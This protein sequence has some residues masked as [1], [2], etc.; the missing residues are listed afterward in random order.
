MTQIIEH[1]TLLFIKLK[2]SAISAH[3]QLIG[4]IL[5]ALNAFER[6]ILSTA[7]STTAIKEIKRP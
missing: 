3:V 2:Y 1:T 4:R 5:T 7:R 6:K